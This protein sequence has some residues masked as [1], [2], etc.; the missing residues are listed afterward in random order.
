MLQLIHPGSLRSFHVSC[1][2]HTAGIENTLN[3]LLYSLETHVLTALTLQMVYN[4]SKRR[5]LSSAATVR[6]MIE[7]LIVNRGAKMLV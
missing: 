1:L 7:P 5:K 6:A 3:V 4:G 2:D